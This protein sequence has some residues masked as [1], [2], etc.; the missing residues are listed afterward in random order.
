MRSR[1][2]PSC[3]ARGCCRRLRA[4]L[5]DLQGDRAGVT[6]IEYALI[7]GIMAAAVAASVPAIG[8]NLSH[9]F[10]AVAQGL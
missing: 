7:A 6:V 9:M 4:A 3:C 1:T 2:K 8:T 5:G 10:G